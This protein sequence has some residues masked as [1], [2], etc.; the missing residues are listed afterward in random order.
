M[1]RRMIRYT[2]AAA[3]L[4]LSLGLA[5]CNDDEADNADNAAD[6]AAETTAATTAE[7][8]SPATSE[9]EDA[10]AAQGDEKIEAEGLDSLT[11]GEELTVNLSGLDTS[12]GYYLALCSADGAKEGPAP[13]CTGGMDG[14]SAWIAAEDN[15]QATDHF[16]AEGNATVELPIVAR[17]EKLDCTVDA[18]DLKLFGDHQNGFQDVTEEPV[19]VM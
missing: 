9:S 14:G 15:A 16:D 5:A 3:A 18:C 6:N 1:T 10:S 8:S 7:E 11:D 2:T 4:T 19:T 13:V 17:S 12:K